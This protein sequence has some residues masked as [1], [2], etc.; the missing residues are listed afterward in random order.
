ME[1][2]FDINVDALRTSPPLLE[3]DDIAVL[4]A[5][6]HR[7]AGPKVTT[8]FISYHGV[9]LYVHSL[10]ARGSNLSILVALATGGKV[11]PANFQFQTPFTQCK[12]SKSIV[13]SSQPLVV[14][15]RIGRAH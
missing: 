8:L 3:N 5:A 2:F 15:S 12:K 14:F 13:Q 1:R 4:T 9:I 6:I 7:S 10:A 11:I